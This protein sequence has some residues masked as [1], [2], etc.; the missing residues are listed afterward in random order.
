MTD[1]DKKWSNVL[2]GVPISEY[3]PTPRLPTAVMS[4]SELADYFKSDKGNIKHLYTETYEKY[5]STI[6]NKKINLLEIG[7]G[8]GCSLKMWHEYFSNGSI[9]GIDIRPECQ[10]LCKSYPRVRITTGDATKT[11]VSGDFD[12]IID[13]GSHISLDIVE[14]FGMNWHSLK[15][16]GFYVIE[17]LRPTY[18]DFIWPH[19]PNYPKSRFERSHFIAFIDALM[20]NVD[21]RGQKEVEY[22]HYYR[23]LLFIKKA[24]A[25]LPAV[26]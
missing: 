3:E 11:P 5:F 18:D 4:L 23:E 22:L 8:N 16:G 9:H 14:A 13:D 19:F 10:Q 24:G 7:V 2:S 17:D 25:P 21:Q 26:C 15:P 20:R 1:D 6:K 12:I